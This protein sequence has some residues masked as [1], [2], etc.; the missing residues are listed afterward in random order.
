MILSDALILSVS[1]LQTQGDDV[2]HKIF[3][4]DFIIYPCA[5]FVVDIDEK[6]NHKGG[7]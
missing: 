3:N 5:D 2:T 6:S 1:Q 4:T 7:F